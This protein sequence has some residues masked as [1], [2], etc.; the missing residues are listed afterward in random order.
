MPKYDKRF[1][2]LCVVLLMEISL[3]IV[4][5]TLTVSEDSFILSHSVEIC[6]IPVSS[7]Q[8]QT[9]PYY[10]TAYDS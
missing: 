3:E 5:G 10:V 7:S 8:L 4:S 6:A 2:V 1:F 9:E